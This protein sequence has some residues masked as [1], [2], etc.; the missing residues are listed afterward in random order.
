MG[1]QSTG[2]VRQVIHGIGKRMA[3]RVGAEREVVFAGYMAVS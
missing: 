2:C 1:G 3:E